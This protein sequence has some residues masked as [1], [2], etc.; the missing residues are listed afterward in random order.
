MVQ[1]PPGLSPCLLRAPSRSQ[2]ELPRPGLGLW[3]SPHLATLTWPS[4]GRM[5]EAA[6]SPGWS[7]GL[8]GERVGI[9]S[10]G[11]RGLQRKKIKACERRAGPW[12]GTSDLARANCPH[13]PGCRLQGSRPRSL[14]AEGRG[15]ESAFGL[16]PGGV[17]SQTALVPTVCLERWSRWPS[18]WV[19]EHSVGFTGELVRNAEALAMPTWLGQEFGAC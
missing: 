17:L 13:C 16:G 6:L 12:G 5:A 11:R 18:E 9:I 3:R 19:P 7:P 1:P 4:P 15:V 10:A 2:E 8:C 14:L